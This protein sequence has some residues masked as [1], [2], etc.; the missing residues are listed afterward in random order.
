M[1]IKRKEKMHEKLK[2]HSNLKSK[3][4]VRQLSHI[5]SIIQAWERNNFICLFLA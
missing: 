1:E 2:G 4:T 5:K 3:E